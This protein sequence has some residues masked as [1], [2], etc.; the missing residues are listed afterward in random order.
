[1]LVTQ[2]TQRELRGE[3]CCHSKNGV[4]LICTKEAGTVTSFTMQAD[5]L[6]TTSGLEPLGHLSL[7]HFP[8]PG[9]LSL[10]FS[11][12]QLFA[13]ANPLVTFLPRPPPHDGMDVFQFCLTCSTSSS[14]NVI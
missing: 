12:L 6:K 13:E 11:S 14:L 3:C 8:P 1:M 5:G 7:F 4:L 2:H 9:Y 10:S